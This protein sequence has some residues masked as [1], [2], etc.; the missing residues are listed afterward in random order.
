ME[1]SFKEAKEDKG[2][3]SCITE[4]LAYDSKNCS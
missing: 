3:I 4:K 2:I 1:T